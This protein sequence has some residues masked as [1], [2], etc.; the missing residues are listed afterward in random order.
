MMKRLFIALCVLLSTQMLSAQIISSQ[1]VTVRKVEKERTYYDIPKGYRGFAEVAYSVNF[2]DRMA[3]GFDVLTTHG[4]Q[5]NNW[6]FIGAGVGFIGTGHK[7]YEGNISIEQHNYPTYNSPA[8]RAPKGSVGITPD[9]YQHYEES[10]SHIALSIPLYANVRVYCSRTQIK[11]FVDLKLGGII[12]LNSIITEEKSIDCV[13][14]E[15]CDTDHS[16][17]SSAQKNGGFYGQLGLGVEY[18]RYA[19]SINYALRGCKHE[20]THISQYW[21]NSQPEQSTETSKSINPAILTV[22]FGVNF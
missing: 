7:N 3:S 15:Y 2:L 11:P 19:L 13:V 21:N 20:S 6:L 14:G 17:Y 16:T 9:I 10:Q 18:K 5:C 4:Y 22:N 12:P 8:M 1:S